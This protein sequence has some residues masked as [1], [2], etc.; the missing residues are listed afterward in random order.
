MQL[1]PSLAH[2]TG[3]SASFSPLPSAPSLLLLLREPPQSPRHPLPPTPTLQEHLLSLPEADWTDEEQA[4]SNA[5]LT[6]RN[7]NLG[8]VKPGARAIVLMFSDHNGNQVAR[9]PWYHRFAP[10]VEPIVKQVRVCGVWGG[11]RGCTPGHNMWG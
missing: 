2:Q 4:R 1:V 11:G 6:G 9:F 10:L 8:A 7:A 5:Y 3:E